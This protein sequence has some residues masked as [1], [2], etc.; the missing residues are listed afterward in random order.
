[1]GVLVTET[2][3]AFA[4]QGPRGWPIGVTSARRRTPYGL[5]LRPGSK[6][7]RPAPQLLGFVVSP[8][9]LFCCSVVVVPKVCV[10]V[11]AHVFLFHSTCARANW[12]SDDV[13]L[14]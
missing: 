1:M 4:L 5:P 13:S 14:R 8:A 7:C 10:C 3:R 2:T 12:A 6:A 11:C 9:L